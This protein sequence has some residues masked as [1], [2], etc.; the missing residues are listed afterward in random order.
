MPAAAAARSAAARSFPGAVSAQ[1]AEDLLAVPS[2]A[3]DAFGTLAFWNEADLRVQATGGGGP[4]SGP[5]DLC[6]TPPDHRVA[7][8]A[9]GYDDVLYVALQSTIGGSASIGLFD[10]RRRW[11]PGA[12]FELALPVIPDRLAADPAGGV[13]VLDRAARTIGRV[14]GLPLRDGLPPS[15]APTTFR[16]RPEN[17]AEPHFALDP[18]QPAWVADEIPIALACNSAGR[19]AV[20]TWILGETWLH[21][22]D[23]AT[24]RWR[25]AALAGQRGAADQHRVV[26][27]KADRRAAR[28]ARCSRPRD[29]A[30][31]GSTRLRPG[32][33]DTRE[34]ERAAL[35]RAR[36]H[37]SAR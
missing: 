7:D 18:H 29:C 22:R 25:R 9:L 20:M 30:S 24:G 2:R 13:W 31:E 4:A 28:T 16:P 6:E 34:R 36:R 3:G 8:L 33:C 26:L 5:V 12:L 10:L 27:G 21:L 11:N 19:L 14:R 32:R 23:A 1:A 17:I 15:F 37:V 35:G